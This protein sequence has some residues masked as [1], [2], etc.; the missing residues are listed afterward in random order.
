MKTK[1]K[2]LPATA[3]G[4]IIHPKTAHKFRVVHT[5]TPYDFSAPSIAEESRIVTLQTVKCVPSKFVQYGKGSLLITLEDD[6]DN[7]ML[8]Y[9]NQNFDGYNEFLIEF[10]DGD[11]VVLS[12]IHAK[13]CTLKHISSEV[14]YIPSGAHQ[15]VLY[16]EVANLQ[17]LK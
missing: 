11:I 17:Y 3:T 14:T 13:D 15:F 5:N 4:G 12:R 8:D 16:F 1:L 9:I 10:L 2:P 7:R 6:K